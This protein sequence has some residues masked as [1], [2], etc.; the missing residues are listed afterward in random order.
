M[1][2]RDVSNEFRYIV[3]R[4]GCF[5]F[6]ADTDRIRCNTYYPLSNVSGE[7]LDAYANTKFEHR[8]NA[9]AL[10]NE[11]VTYKMV[12]LLFGVATEDINELPYVAGTYKTVNPIVPKLYASCELINFHDVDR[13]FHDLF[14]ID[15]SAAVHYITMIFGAY[16]LRG[17]VLDIL[18][19]EKCYD[20][21]QRNLKV[22]LGYTRQ[23]LM[24]EW[25]KDFL[26]A[27]APQDL[28]SYEDTFI[29]AATH[30]MDVLEARL[31]LLHTWVEENTKL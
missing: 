25:Y 6:N 20:T 21:I 16:N 24:F 29:Y 14:R 7:I 22:M 1:A 17:E 28:D 5:I 31:G 10:W 2:A 19:S 12:G 4:F 15:P 11:Y 13:V 8:E 3:Q 30:C 23:I 26:E 9:E 18:R 27:K